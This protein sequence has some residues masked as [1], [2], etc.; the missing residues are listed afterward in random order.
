VGGHGAVRAKGQST[1]GG[2]TWG[3]HSNSR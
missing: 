3:R 1:Y 2:M